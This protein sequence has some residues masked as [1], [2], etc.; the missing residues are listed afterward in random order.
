MP[1]A[2]LGCDS[3]LCDLPPPLLSGALESV[4]NQ[5]GI[6][7]QLAIDRL[8][9]STVFIGGP[10]ELPKKREQLSCFSRR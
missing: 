5:G 3:V 6:A 7:K 4:L 9:R 1:G 10:A 2:A 8:S